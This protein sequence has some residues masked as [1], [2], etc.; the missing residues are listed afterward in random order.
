NFNIS[1]NKNKILALTDDEQF[2]LS[3]VA[4]D[5]G[6][7]DFPYI[8]RVGES[9]ATFFGTVWDGNYGYE[10]FDVTPGG[11]YTLKPGLPT[12]SADVNVKPKPGDIKYRDINGDGIINGDDR[13]NIGRPLP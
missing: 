10:D 6:F 13:V 12:N 9:A 1:F 8:A 7:S 4:W 5:S 11:V 3:S 2:M